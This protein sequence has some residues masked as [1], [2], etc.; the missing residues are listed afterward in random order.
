[1][2]AHDSGK[3]AR[4]VSLDAYR[5]AVMLLMASS[6][7]GLARVAEHFDDRPSWGLVGEQVEHAEWV[8]CTL[9][10][11]IQPAFMFVVGVAL[12]FSI[13]SRR[14]RGQGFGTL[15][16][17]ALWRSLALVLLAVFLTSAWS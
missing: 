17:H 14:A 8:G 16:A 6:G 5:G 1:M 3:P 12:P 13:A 7:L 2:N 4:L 10:D 15:L 9:W 11:L